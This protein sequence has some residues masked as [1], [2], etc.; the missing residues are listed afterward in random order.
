MRVF[1]Q[2]ARYGGLDSKLPHLAG[3][4]LCLFK[5]PSNQSLDG[6]EGIQGVSLA[7]PATSTQGF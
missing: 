5:G 2:A 4:G 7:V 6:V 1:Y 3:I